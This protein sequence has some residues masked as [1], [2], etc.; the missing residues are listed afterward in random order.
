M[1]QRRLGKLK[2]IMNVYE[3]R[4]EYNEHLCLKEK[5]VDELKKLL[6]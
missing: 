4:I 6:N 5:E 2:E 1:L 3:I